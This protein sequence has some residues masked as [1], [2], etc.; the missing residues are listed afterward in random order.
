MCLLIP[1]FVAYS[2]IFYKIIEIIIP[3]KFF[4]GF[5]LRKKTVDGASDFVGK[6]A[7]LGNV[8]VLF[9]KMFVFMVIWV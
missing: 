9:D 2:A 5:F 7:M 8:S 1:V 3:M 4:N 6:I